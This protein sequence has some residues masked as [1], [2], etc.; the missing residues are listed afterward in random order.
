MPTSRERNGTRLKGNVLGKVIPDGQFTLLRPRE[1]ILGN[2]KLRQ[3]LGH[4]A[5]ER[6]TIVVL[7]A[8]KLKEARRGAGCPVGLDKDV[9][10]VHVLLGVDGDFAAD[11]EALIFASDHD[12]LFVVGVAGWGSDEMPFAVEFVAEFMAIESLA[13]MPTAS[14]RDPRLQFPALRMLGVEGVVLPIEVD[15]L[16]GKLVHEHNFQRIVVLSVDERRVSGG[17]EGGDGRIFQTKDCHGSFF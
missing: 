12:E 7:I 11:L 4:N 16:V 13:G 15:G 2:T 9:E 5:I 14:W 17:C 8:H 10:V 3:K 6:H 1:V